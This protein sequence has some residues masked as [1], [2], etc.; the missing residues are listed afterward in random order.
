[1]QRE[2]REEI[3]IFSL[4]ILMARSR[5]ILCQ[6]IMFGSRGGLLFGYIFLNAFSLIFVFGIQYFVLVTTCKLNN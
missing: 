2:K 1:M 4:T 6:F 3:K 5:I